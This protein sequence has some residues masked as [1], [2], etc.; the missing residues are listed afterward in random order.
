V[1]EED[2]GSDHLAAVVGQDAADLEAAEVAPALV[3]DKLDHG[4]LRWRSA[5]LSLAR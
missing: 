3:D 4:S 2:E 5:A 1:I